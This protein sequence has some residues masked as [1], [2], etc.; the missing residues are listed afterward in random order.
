MG[1]SGSHVDEDTDG[2]EDELA[3]FPKAGFHGDPVVT[4]CAGN[5]GQLKQADDYPGTIN[6]MPMMRYGSFTEEAS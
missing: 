2:T 4:N 1:D 5:G 3:I 6:A